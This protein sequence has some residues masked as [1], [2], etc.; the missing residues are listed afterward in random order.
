[1]HKPKNNLMR[2]YFLFILILI[3]KVLFSA[4]LTD[5]RNIL[6][7]LNADNNLNYSINV[8]ID[9]N[10]SHGYA[11]VQGFG[12]N[13]NIYVHGTELARQGK[14][15]WA[16]VMGHEL[17]HV[18]LQHSGTNDKY[19]EFNADANGAKLAINSGYSVSN[20]IRSLYN[21]HNS[22]S[23]THGCWHERAKRLEDKFEIDTGLRQEHHEEHE[24][25]SGAFPPTRLNIQVRV[26]CSHRVVCSHR[27]QCGHKMQCG[28]SVW[29]GYQ[30]VRPHPFDTQHQ[31]DA[32]HQFDF[33]HWFDLI[34]F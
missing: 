33:Q 29:N 17:S 7:S 32:Q 11:A 4:N 13:V 18:I 26:Q 14:N 22:C 34:T 30:Y 15:T 10:R 9:N 21:E 27:I 20:Y 28:H 6:S 25:G 23:P 1:M 24:V 31:F 8:S 12:N 3:S 5:L 2:F 19:D 16:F